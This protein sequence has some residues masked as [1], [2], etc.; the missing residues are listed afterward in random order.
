MT[1]SGTGRVAIVTGGSGGIGQATSLRLSRDCSA[2]VVH[3]S[4]SE[5]KADEAVRSIEDAGGSAIAVKGDIGDEG[6]VAALFDKT[7]EAYGGVDVVVNTAGIMLLS[8]LADLDFDDFDRMFRVNV[9]GAYLVTQ[10]AARRVRPGGAIVNFSSSVTRLSQP[11]YSA[12]AGTKAAMEALTPILARELAGK[13]IT[14][15]TV[16][17]GPVATPLFLQGKPQAVIDH[18]AEMSPMKRLGEP[19]DI[20]EVVA[21]LAG[22]ARWINGQVI[23]ANGGI[24]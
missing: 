5:K 15:N 22:P 2:V 17:P 11:N 21:Y 20:A 6:D 13:D 14:V 16:A 1:E 10:Q 4:G 24:A 23:Y 18:L 8:P 9:R 3:Y 19:E 7:T 12:Y